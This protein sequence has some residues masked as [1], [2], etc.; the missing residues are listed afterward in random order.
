MVRK[1]IAIR[2]KTEAEKRKL[3][4]RSTFLEAL[5][6]MKEKKLIEKLPAKNAKIET[7]RKASS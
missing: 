6:E 4:K 3:T 7:L 1:K 2:P 5:K